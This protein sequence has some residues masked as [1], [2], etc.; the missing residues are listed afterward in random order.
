M[1]DF[2]KRSDQDFR[3]QYN[4]FAT[5]LPTY[6]ATLGLTAGDMTMVSQDHEAIEFI[7][8]RYQL[9]GTFSQ[10]W[11]TTKD[12]VRKGTGTLG[13]LPVPPDVS[14]P[15]ANINP[16][17]EGRFR[18]LAA[19]IKTAPGYNLNIGQA[20]HIVAPEEVVDYSTYRPELKLELTAGQVLIKWKKQLADGINIYKQNARGE[21]ALLAFDG[22]PNY[23]DKSILPPAGTTAQWTY[24]AAYVV[25]DAEVG[26]YSEAVTITVTGQV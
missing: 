13:P 2:V 11:T 8:T 20:L 16:G 10:N 22:R 4:E 9:A 7:F 21:W 6:Q 18:A 1:A 24:K 5:N 25:D 15:P 26:Q 19:R 12:R 3:D 14:A 23:L 17:V